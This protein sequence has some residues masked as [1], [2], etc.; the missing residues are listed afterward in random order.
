MQNKLSKILYYISFIVGIAL[1]LLIFAQVFSVSKYNNTP[2]IVKSTDI[3]DKMSVVITPRTGDSARW[4]K[5]NLGVEG[6][7]FDAT[8][9]NGTTDIVN[10][11]NLRID[12]ERDCY[13]SQFWNGEVEIHQHVNDPEHEE[14]VQTINLAKYDVNELEVDYI[15][16]GPDLMVPLKIGDYMI[17]HPSEDFN[18]IP[19]GASSDVTVGFIVYYKRYIEFRDYQIDYYYQKNIIQGP[20]FVVS[21][22]LAFALLLTVGMNIATTYI[23]NRAEKEMELRK[24][25]ISCMMG[26][27]SAIYIIDVKKNTLESVGENE[28]LI[29]RPKSA[30]A[31][32]QLDYI[33]KTEPEDQYKALLADFSK[34]DFLKNEIREK[35]TIVAEFKSVNH[36]WFRIRFLSMD[37]AG[38]SV[39]RIL[40]TVHDID[41]ERQKLDKAKEHAQNIESEIRQ[42]NEIMEGVFKEAKTPV[43]SILSL[44]EQIMQKTENDEI[45][46][47]SQEIKRIGDGFMALMDDSLDYS[48][49]ESGKMQIEAKAYS[50]ADMT[51]EIKN[52][53]ASIITNKDIE[54]ETDI[55]DGIPE[56]LIGDAEKIIQVVLNLIKSNLREINK[57]SITLRIYAGAKDETNVHMLFSVREKGNKNIIPDDEMDMFIARGIVSL[58]GSEI[59]TARIGEGCDYYFEIE[60][61]LSK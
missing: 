60:Q 20:L 16:D 28:N 55:A 38:H 59:K 17:Y 2:H 32:E 48:Q 49:I 58:M 33:F 57:G 30:S 61:G 40:M 35:G 46:S 52:S 39:G 4:P 11:W 9:H 50:F 6:G 42:K 27:Y 12:I 5:S 18:E 19:L 31:E 29:D 14:I 54:F 7:I 10:D 8:F 24:S 43:K 56:T 37:K 22:V 34:L 21:C 1:V 26:L 51:N 23:Y 3:D 13:I 45:K 53:A 44:N 15:I 36:G 25:G 41:D 47:L